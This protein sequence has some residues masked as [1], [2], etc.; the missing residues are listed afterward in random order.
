MPPT[1]RKKKDCNIEPTPSKDDSD[2]GNEQH[3]HIYEHGTTRCLSKGQASSLILFS[4]LVA[5]TLL[6]LKALR[7][8]KPLKSNSSMTRPKHSSLVMKYSISFRS[9]CLTPQT[10]SCSLE[11]VHPRRLEFPALCG[12]LNPTTFADFHV[13]NPAKDLPHAPNF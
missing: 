9:L 12:N 1:H 4:L 8:Q 2:D 3:K 11:A 10:F 6:C 5:V 13:L 7:N